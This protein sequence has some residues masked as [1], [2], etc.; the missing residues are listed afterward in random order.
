[1]LVAELLAVNGGSLPVEDFGDRVNGLR[2][3]RGWSQTHLSEATG[4]NQSTISKLERGTVL[5]TREQAEL[6]AT[7]FGVRPGWMLYGDGSPH[8][9]ETDAEREAAAFNAGR[10]SAYQDLAAYA[11]ERAGWYLGKPA[12]QGS[13]PSAGSDAN[14]EANAILDDVNRLAGDLL[15]GA[16]K[17]AGSVKKRA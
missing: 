17:R 1:M 4:I 15:S 7:A 6:M 3:E 13:D 2:V 16:P 11:S 8:L 10:L 5:P 9:G 12:G 14:A